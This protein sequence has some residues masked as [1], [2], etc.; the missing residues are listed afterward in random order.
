MTLVTKLFLSLQVQPEA[1]TEEFFQFENQGEPPSLTDM[2][3]FAQVTSQLSWNWNNWMLTRH[4]E[5]STKRT[6]PRLHSRC[7]NGRCM[8]VLKLPPIKMQDPQT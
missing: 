2:A 4:S 6:L 5:Y 3:G 1:N 8:G 7:D